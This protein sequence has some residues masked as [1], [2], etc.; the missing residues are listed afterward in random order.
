MIESR[1]IKAVTLDVDGTLYDIRWMVLRNI[2]VMFP[3]LDFFRDLHK[4]RD[5]MRKEGHFSDFRKEQARRLAKIRG[6]RHGQASRQVEEVIDNRWGKAFRAIKPYKGVETTLAEFHKRG[7]RLGLVSDYPL[8]YKIK[9]LRL[10]GLPFET[11]IVTERVGALK[12]HPAAFERAAAELGLDPGLVLHV[13]DREDCDVEGALKA[14]MKT[15]LFSRKARKQESRANIV[16][17]DW[18]KLIQ[19]LEDADMLTTI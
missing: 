2:L 12:P 11:K 5:G 19:L 1:H 7:V 3:V 8:E 17:S 6:I 15:A 13:G 10:G 18:R 16:F 14:G 9:G 4:V